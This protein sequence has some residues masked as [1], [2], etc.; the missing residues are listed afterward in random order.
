MHPNVFISFILS[1][2]IFSGGLVC[3]RV[4]PSKKDQLLLLEVMG[5][6]FRSQMIP[7][8]RKRRVPE[9]FLINSSS[10]IRSSTLYFPKSSK[11][12]GD[13]VASGYHHGISVIRNS[14]MIDLVVSLSVS[15]VDIMIAGLYS[16]EVH[17]VRRFNSRRSQDLVCCFLTNTRNLSGYVFM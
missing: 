6:T 14:W 1:Q 16:L 3:L 13:F 5:S 2:L 11:T 7:I 10:L 17:S 4:L 12:L 15:E 9:Y 8:P